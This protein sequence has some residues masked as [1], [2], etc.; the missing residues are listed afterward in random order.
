MAEEEFIKQLDGYLYKE[1]AIFYTKEKTS[2]FKEFV[3]NPNNAN[4]IIF[5]KNIELFKEDILEL[6]FSKNNIVLS[7]DVDKSDCR[8]NIL[9]KK[10]CTKIFFSSLGNMTVKLLQK[11]EGFLTS[12]NLQGIT[13]VKFH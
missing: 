13:K 10:F 9:N 2:E 11:Y 8:Q 1:K 5:I 7:G 3:I 4:R 12:N 6:V